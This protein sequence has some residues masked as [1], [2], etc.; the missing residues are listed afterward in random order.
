M[1]ILLFLDPGL[2]NCPFYRL[3]KAKCKTLTVFFEIPD[4]P[5]VLRPS[6]Y[7]FIA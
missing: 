7:N 6:F 1:L 3:E 4:F 2:Y 5:W